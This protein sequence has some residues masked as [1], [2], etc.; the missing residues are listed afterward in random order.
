MIVSSAKAGKLATTS[1]FMIALFF[2]GIV[3]TMPAHAAEPPRS[4]RH[5]RS[6]E[7]R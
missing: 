5:F 6:R 1:L 7:T 2:M 3:V 4:H